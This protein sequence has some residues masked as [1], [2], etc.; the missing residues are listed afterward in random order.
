MGGSVY[1]QEGICIFECS[2]EGP[3]LRS[4]RDATDLMSEARSQGAKF[5]VIPA[6]RL[7][8]DFF[9]LRTRIAGEIAQKFVTY[10]ARVAVVG[11][12]SERVAKSQS[13][14]AFVSEANRG[15]NLWFVTNREE[16]TARLAAGN[17]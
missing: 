6:E 14:S 2:P 9:D 11:D 4:A 12:I 3:Q 17:S 5:I 16:L 13:L 8:D 10:G 7:G 1:E 15:K